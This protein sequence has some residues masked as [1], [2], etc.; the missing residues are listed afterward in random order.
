VGIQS[1][2][3]KSSEVFGVGF[4]GG[5]LLGRR[6]GERVSLNGELTVDVGNRHRVLPDRPL[7]FYAADLVFSPLYHAVLSPAAMVVAG[8]RLGLWGGLGQEHV[9][10]VSND[11]WTR[12]VSAGL[13]LGAFFG[14]ASRAALGGLISLG[15]RKPLYACYQPSSG[16][17]RCASDGLGDGVFNIGM[18]AAALF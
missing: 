17:E 7:S 16:A 11:T 15:W 18:T 9:G 14:V 12:G 10:D 1:F 2:Q 13:Q 3:G 6:L 4:R 5:V 8:P